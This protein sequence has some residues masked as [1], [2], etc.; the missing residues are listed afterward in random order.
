MPRLSVIFEVFKEDPI[1]SELCEN[2]FHKEWQT[3]KWGAGYDFQ[4]DFFWGEIKAAGRNIL[5][6]AWLRR[7]IIGLII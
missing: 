1:M 2:I 5:K 4:R 3:L 6:N 7:I